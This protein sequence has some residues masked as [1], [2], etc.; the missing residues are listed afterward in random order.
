MNDNAKL[1]KWLNKF[2]KQPH[3]S[4]PLADASF[5]NYHRLVNQSKNLLVM[6]SSQELA[7]LENFLI[8]HQ[9]FNQTLKVPKIYHQDKKLGYLV[10][11]D[12]GDK[13]FLTI[14][15]PT[16][17]VLYKQA[18]DD[19]VKLQQIDTTKLANYDDVLLLKELTL[20]SQWYLRK[21]H[22]YEPNANEIVR[23][24]QVFT[25]LIDQIQSQEQ[26]VVHRDYH[27]RNII[28]TTDNKLAYLDFQDAVIGAYSYDVCSLLKDAYYQL[29]DNKLE[30]LLQYFYTQANIKKSYVNFLFDFDIASIQRQLKV[31][32]IF[33]RLAIRDDKYKYLDYI[34][35]VEKYLL[36]TLK[37]YP[38]L[39]VIK[40]LIK[41]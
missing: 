14:Q 23:L 31:L 39:G 28:L 32:G 15:N 34:P 24:N 3:L 9:L 38:H 22:Q 13:L 36:A 41:R 17:L 2:F 6:D 29:N 18:L 5:R 40:E 35:L 16:N 25:L 8:V 30:Q 10:L 37:K 4:A 19:L 12:L 26:V 27:S 1:I 11:E 7:S 21:Y 33:S 20:F